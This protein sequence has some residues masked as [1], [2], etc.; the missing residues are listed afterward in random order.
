MEKFSKVISCLKNG[1][2]ATRQA[3]MSEG[4]EIMM[5]IP[6][7]IAKDIVPKMT[8]VQPGIKPKISTV[9]SGEIEYHDQVIILTF[10]DDEKTPVRATYYVP[11]W[12]D[13]FADDWMLSETVDSYVGRMEDELRDLGEKHQDLLS[14]FDTRIFKEHLSDEKKELMKQQAEVM[15][16]YISVLGKRLQLERQEK[17]DGK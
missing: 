14:F 3:W 13:I 17:E 6:Q 11:T 16:D 9:G 12:E 7:R 10:V 8:S 5:Q 1:G 15:S 4:K 2:T